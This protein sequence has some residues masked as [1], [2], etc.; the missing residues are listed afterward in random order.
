MDSLKSIIATLTQGREHSSNDIVSAAHEVSQSVS[1]FLSEKGI[2][3]SS[4]SNGM[5][6]LTGSFGTESLVSIGYD[7]IAQMVEDNHV[8][9]E[10]REQATEEISIILA[11]AAIAGGNSA[12]MVSSH[13]KKVNLDNSA[14]V[15]GI[16]RLMPESVYGMYNKSYGTEHFGVDT[17]KLQSDLIS[18]ITISLMKWHKAISPR[19]L[20]TIASSNP[21]VVYKRDEYMI[22]DLSDSET[23]LTPAVG[24]YRDP[25]TVANQLQTIV[26]ISSGNDN[27]DVDGIIPLDTDVNLFDV[28]LNSNVYGHGTVNRTDLI[29]DDIKI[30]NI[31]VKASWNDGSDKTAALIIP[32]PSSRGTLY[33]VPRT[34]STFRT[35]S[36]DYNVQAGSTFKNA[37]GAEIGASGGV[38]AYAMDAGVSDVINI[39]LRVTT[40]LDI[41]TSDFNSHGTV[42]ATA[43]GD[44]GGPKSGND[45]DL[46]NVV[47]T[48]DGIEL[49]ARYSEENYRKSNIVCTQETSELLYEIPPGRVFGADRSHNQANDAA[50]RDKQVATLMSIAAIGQDDVAIRAIKGY[51]DTVNDETAL[52]SSDP[53]NNPRP[54]LLYAAGGKVIPSVIYDTLP[55]GDIDSFDDA[56]RRAAIIQ[57]VESFLGSVVCELMQSSFM[58][59]QMAPNTTLTFRCLTTGTILSNVIAVGTENKIVASDGVE[60]AIKLPDGTILEFITTTFDSFGD[61]IMMVPVIKGAPN[62]DLNFGHNRSCG[63]SVVQFSASYETASAMRL[64]ASLRELPV[65]TNVVGAM[66]AV[67]GV[68]VAAFRATS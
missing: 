30:K 7:G 62:S 48:I 4:E 54:G 2:V 39:Q 57:K 37:A 49:D 24:L 65:P 50:A 16:E 9:E 14:S 55:L 61:N 15:I 21:L 32:I 40:N 59:Q 43:I 52:Y 45:S 3:G 13:L 64:M 53:I 17:D 44:D 66:I 56:R 28:S 36:L 31:I 46:A 1:V 34:K 63:T 5:H 12:A 35:L 18:A 6:V 58:K 10:Y 8:P 26:P 19:L 38:W 20:P 29:A 41:R 11:R 23:E 51:L 67:T 47:F 42:V 27:I 33:R 22:F 60:Y 68:D 25:S